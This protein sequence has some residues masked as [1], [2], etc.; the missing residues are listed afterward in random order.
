MSALTFTTTNE[1]FR[2]LLGNGMTYRVPPFQ[3]DYAW[4]PEEWDDL[5]QDIQGLFE[6]DGESDHY[7][8]YLV[9]QST[10][11][12]HFDIIDGQQRLTTLSLLV[13]AGLD[14]LRDLQAK[15]LD[16][17]RNGRRV[18]TLR[19]AYIGFLDPVSLTT[20]NKLTLNRH[21]DAFYRTYVVPLEPL[22]KR[23]LN[24]AER[25]LRQA[26]IEFKE[27]MAKRFGTEQDS[28]ERLA[29]FLDAM[30]DR[31]FFTTITVTDELNAFKVFE[32]LNARG[33][34]LSAPDLLKNYLFSLLQA[35]DAHALEQ[36]QLEDRWDRIVTVLEQ[37]TFAEFL[38]VFWNSRHKLVRKTEL[39]KQIRRTV[40]T[41]EEAFALLRELDHAAEAYANLR[42]PQ[43]EVWSV[44]ESALLNQLAMFSVRQPL[45]TLLAAYRRFFESE[46]A[47]FT[48][49]LQVIVI[50]SFRY[51]VICNMLTHD[52]ERVYNEVARRIS[53]GSLNTGREILAELRTLYPE[54]RLF[55]SNFL[56]KTFSTNNARN[57]KVVRYIL[58]QLE[59]HMYSHALHPD[60]QR[61]TLEHV[62][63][64]NAEN[65]W[66]HIDA[67]KQEQLASRLGNMALLEA[68]MNRQLANQ[69]FES[70]RVAYAD[71][72][73]QL[74]QA[75]AEVAEWTADAIHRRQARMA[76]AATAIWRIDFGDPRERTQ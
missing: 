35:S 12:K 48:R 73:V 42:D 52:Q 23:K 49:V 71:S 21:G 8:G 38:R 39:F 37:E 46:R 53:D 17:E 4:G 65:G 7:L 26:F 34:K 11:G 56:E 31:L 69:A 70:K 47:T 13:L 28:G 9:L 57:A 3:R 2:K 14:H 20:R 40:T 61:Y 41:R 72:T 50:V 67:S 10:D 62:L 30:V 60:G 76:K 54:D 59:Q 18:D 24:A 68:G 16:A 43:A 5:W 25:Q 45:S 29:A 15:G 44:G 22:P 36:Q 75:L 51:N 19:S 64:Q 58:Q 32:T 33:V 74:T 6:P 27:R 1:T 63:P 66:E 55:E